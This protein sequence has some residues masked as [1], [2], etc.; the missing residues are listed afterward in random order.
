MRICQER[1]EI[2]FCT[3]FFHLFSQQCVLSKW[4]WRL[5]VANCGGRMRSRLSWGRS[6][7]ETDATRWCWGTR[8]AAWF[9]WRCTTGRVRKVCRLVR[10]NSPT[11]THTD[12][13]TRKNIY[14]KKRSCQWITH[15]CSS[16]S[17]SPA[18]AGS[19]SVSAS[20][21]GRN[22]CQV[23]NGGCSQL[24]FPTSENSRSCSC[25]VGYNLRSDRMSCEGM[26]CSCV[27]LYPDCIWCLCVFITWK[28]IHKPLSGSTYP[29]SLSTP[30][31]TNDFNLASLS[32]KLLPECAVYLLL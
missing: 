20:R 7:R 27:R 3:L 31:S 29:T 19:A 24:C 2:L 9:T 8:R 18:A 14:I 4:H 28:Y 13:H 25:T 30:T 21:S 11:H 5:Q 16:S 22:P 17:H 15:T 10:I 32:T 6:P 26:H 23:N 1:S 12:R